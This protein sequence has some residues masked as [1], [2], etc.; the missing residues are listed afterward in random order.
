M[1]CAIEFDWTDACEALHVNGLRD[2]ERT[3][4]HLCIVIRMRWMYLCHSTFQSL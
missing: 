2:E 1:T 4:L 3:K